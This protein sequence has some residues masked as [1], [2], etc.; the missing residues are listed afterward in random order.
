MVLT[1]MPGQ[2]HL[3]AELAE[4]PSLVANF[5]DKEMPALR[6]LGRLIG[7]HQPRVILT[8]ARGS[9]DNA[10]AHFKFVC[11]TITGCPVTSLAPAHGSLYHTR[12]RVAGAV[13]ISVSQ[14]GRGP[15]LLALQERARSGGALTIAIVNDVTSPLAEQAH[16]VLPL[17]A[18]PEHSIAASK[19]CV[20][21]MVA[22]AALVAEWSTDDT[23]RR[24]VRDL[25]Q[26]FARAV[27]ADW[28]AAE[29]L[30]HDATSAY[31]VG[32][33]P[34]LSIAS[35][36]ALKLKETCALHAEAY[37]G[38]EI[39]HGPLQLLR[40]GFP[41]LAFRQPD[42]A[43]EALVGTIARLRQ[44]GGSVLVA[45]SA[46]AADLPAFRTGH[47]ALDPVAMLLS[48]YRMVERLS[49]LKGQDPDRPLLLNKVTQTY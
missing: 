15:D 5:L 6:R 44:A 34:G 45:D 24:A 48:F 19:T 4:T 28:S 22:M 36:A 20:L 7:E 49:R 30:L 18:G 37:S 16:E 40:P 25:P 39:M 12:L 13:M 14:S 41:V 35:E 26:P 17:H 46:Q 1:A 27:A 3:A 32:R 23:L 31:V 29:R 38:A 47:P 42:A 21:S 33:G 11:E 2:T 10:A 8:G 43:A 9:S